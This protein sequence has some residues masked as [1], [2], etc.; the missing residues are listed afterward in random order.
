[1]EGSD[2]VRRRLWSDGNKMAKGKQKWWLLVLHGKVAIA[3]EE[4]WAERWRK[5]G[6]RVQYAAG[7]KNAAW[8]ETRI[9]H[10][11]VVCSTLRIKSRRHGVI[12][13]P[14]GKDSGKERE[15]RGAHHRELFNANPRCNAKKRSGQI[16]LE[17]LNTAKGWEILTMQ[18]K[19]PILGS[20][21]DQGKGTKH[22]VD[23]VLC[24]EDDRSK[25]VRAE[26]MTW[27]EMHRNMRNTSERAKNRRRARQNISRDGIKLSFWDTYTDRYP[28]E[29]RI[30]NKR[31]WAGEATKKKEQ[32][33]RR[34][35]T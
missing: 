18:S 25:V 9:L 16:T 28:A 14:G 10:G 12:Q 32:D 34:R 27:G 35:L 17:E 26:I 30:R 15:S 4:D 11:S 19:Q 20:W 2:A 24:R 3:L 7:G 33:K 29:V 22:L 1:M 6:S 13:G 5:G 23:H 8:A 31:K 21:E